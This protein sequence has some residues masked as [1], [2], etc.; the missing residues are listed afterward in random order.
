MRKRGQAKVPPGRGS[1]TSMGK[2]P[3]PGMA[4]ATPNA[5]LW[6]KLPTVRHDVP[7]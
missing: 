3:E 6:E 4:A 5:L 2:T 1:L 7:E